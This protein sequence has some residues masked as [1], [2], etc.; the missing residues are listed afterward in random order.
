MVGGSLVP[1]S[2]LPS[3]SSASGHSC[4]C[5]ARCP[6]A[7][8]GFLAFPLRPKG[9]FCW[10]RVSGGW[11]SLHGGTVRLLRSPSGVFLAAGLVACGSLVPAQGKPRRVPAAP[12]GAGSSPLAVAL[13][14]AS[15]LLPAPVSPF[16]RPPPPDARPQR[17][18]VNSAPILRGAC[19]RAPRA[20]SAPPFIMVGL[21]PL[22]H[23][24]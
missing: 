1:R 11:R 7:L 17:S 21:A 2:A 4:A 10:G 12:S 22:R 9:H 8:R 15:G 6:R 5:F 23:H 19:R 16:H 20:P 14:T 18:R 13:L 3:F 24:K